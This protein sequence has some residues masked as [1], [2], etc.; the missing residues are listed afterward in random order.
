MTDSKLLERIIKKSGLKYKF[1]A[2]KL[3]LSYYVLRKRIDND[4][5]FTATEIERMCEVLNIKSL[6]ERHEFF[7]TA[8]IHDFYTNF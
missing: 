3:D 5:E 1:I 4:T 2:Q 6:G 7:L 8:A